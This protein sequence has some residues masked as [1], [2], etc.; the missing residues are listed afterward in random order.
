MKQRIEPVH[1]DD[2]RDIGKVPRQLELPFDTL[3]LVDR[4]GATLEEFILT[5]LL[6]ILL[7]RWLLRGRNFRVVNAAVRTSKHTAVLCHDGSIC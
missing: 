4:G 2:D 7:K 3:P 6:C 1:A 5:I